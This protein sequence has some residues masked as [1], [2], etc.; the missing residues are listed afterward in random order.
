MQSDEQQDEI[1]RTNG[2]IDEPQ[3]F[4]TGGER[5]GE[6]FDYHH[7]H[8]SG[9]FHKFRS[10][11]NRKRPFCCVNC[12][13][14]GHVYRECTE[15]ITSFGI[16]AIRAP[17]NIQPGPVNKIIRPRCHKHLKNPPDSIPEPSGEPS[18]LYLM[19]QRKDTMG[20]IDFIRGKYPEN[21]NIRKMA[22]LKTYLEE[23]TC[24]ERQRLTMFS[25]EDLWDQIWC[26]AGH[27]GT[28]LYINE[29]LEAKKRFA[30][31]NLKRLLDA[32]ECFWTEQ[33]FGFPKGRKNMHETNI[34]C[35]K[36]E[37]KEESGYTQHEIK[38]ID[39]TPWE[40][41]FVGTNGIAYRHV[42]FIAEVPMNIS[43]PRID[44]SDIKEAGEISN[45]GWFSYEQCMQIIRPYDTA[46]KELLTKIHERYKLRYVD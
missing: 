13:K 26:S 25:F 38:I 1:Q 12:G 4:D 5:E 23:M 37:F 40:E 9:R 16:I 45:Y 33:E 44:F 17:G 39:D 41:N 20:Y 11:W 27:N 3:P 22:I 10:R 6:H 42:Y 14:E 19:V 36:R 2:Q 28:S 35:A 34:E 18:I 46:K 30:K 32:T 24:E 31:L 7:H 43:A 8:P 15:P 29:F 21:D